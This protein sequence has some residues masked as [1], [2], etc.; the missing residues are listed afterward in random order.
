MLH[1]SRNTSEADP[2]LCPKIESQVIANIEKA[3]RGQSRELLWFKVSSGR[4]TASK[5]HDIY[6]KA[7]SVSKSSGLVKPNTI[8]FVAKGVYDDGKISTSPMKWYHNHE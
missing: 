2:D 3:T 8:P 1:Q 7:N 6:T 5:H 4:L